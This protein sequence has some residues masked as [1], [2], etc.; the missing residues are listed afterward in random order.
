MLDLSSF[1]INEHCAVMQSIAEHSPKGYTVRLG[2]LDLRLGGSV[3]LYDVSI[4]QMR[5]GTSI[6]F[7]PECSQRAWTGSAVCQR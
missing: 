4:V 3:D 7:I 5:I 1:I 2:R 6:I